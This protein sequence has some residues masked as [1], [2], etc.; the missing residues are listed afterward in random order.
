VILDDVLVHF[1]DDRAAATL[2]ALGE[3]ARG[4][5]VLLFTHHLHLEPIARRVV[6]A[7]VL[8]VHRLDRAGKGI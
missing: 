8:A 2:S 1:D 6:P 5:Q 3:L 4:T 7:D